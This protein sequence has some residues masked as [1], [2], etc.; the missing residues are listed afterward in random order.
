MF[1]KEDKSEGLEV[2]VTGK[3]QKRKNGTEL[4]QQRGQFVY[5]KQAGVSLRWS[6]RGRVM[7][8]SKCGGCVRDASHIAMG[9]N[10]FASF[11]IDSW[12][13]S[14]NGPALWA[15]NWHPEKL[16]GGPKGPRPSDLCNPCLAA[17][18]EY[19]LPLLASSEVAAE[20]NH[21][22]GHSLSVPPMGVSEKPWRVGLRWPH[23]RWL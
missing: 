18:Q 3:K 9:D 8:S 23:F 12:R 15:L 14:R 1:F 16:L 10:G 4:K 2:N 19:L 20:A 6:W 13:L 11:P 17:Y 5:S 22:A 21:P 7:S